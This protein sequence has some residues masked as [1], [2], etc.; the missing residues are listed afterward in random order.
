MKQSLNS[1]GFADGVR[2]SDEALETRLLRSM[3]VSIAIAVVLTA[4]F[5]PWRATSG[6]V[7]GGLLSILNYRWLNNSVTAVLSI[8]L[9]SQRP[10]L[11]ASRFLL[12]YVI[13]GAVIFTAYNVQIISLAAA[14]AGLCSFVPALF[15]EAG[16]EFYF[17]I[18][19]REESH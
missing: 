1:A 12:R 3:I 10:R 16:R 19:H 17:A 18:I 6:L 11:G 14:L 7:L 5:A 8:G 13:I 15:V 9:P 4:I 2:D